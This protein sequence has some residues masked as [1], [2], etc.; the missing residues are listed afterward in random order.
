M[1]G[2]G[3]FHYWILNKFSLWTSSNHSEKLLKKD[4]LFTYLIIS[5]LFSLILGLNDWKTYLP[6]KNCHYSHVKETS[7]ISSL[8]Q[9]FTDVLQNR[10][11][12]W[13]RKFHRKT[14]V[15]VSLFNKVADLQV[16]IKKRLNTGVFLSNLRI[17]EFF[18]NT[19]LHRTPPV[20]A[21]VI[22]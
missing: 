17:C 2:I 11:S 20:A 18:K 10:F 21:S 12:Y 19:F 9:S 14:T 5:C 13:F 15:L 7:L 4:L 16:F 8:E 6:N 3:H 1:R 22:N